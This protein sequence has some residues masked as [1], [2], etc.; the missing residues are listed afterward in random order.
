MKKKVMC[1]LLTGVM[2]ASMFAGCGSSETADTTTDAAATDAATTD[3]AATADA[4]DTTS[5]VLR[6]VADTCNII[7]CKRRESG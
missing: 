6:K 1:M 3:A 7:K 5:E 2:A 4:A